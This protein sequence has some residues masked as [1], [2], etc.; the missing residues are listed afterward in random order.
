MLIKSQLEVCLPYQVQ[1]TLPPHPI[2]QTLLFDFRESGSKTTEQPTW[3]AEFYG[4]LAKE[5]KLIAVEVKVQQW[6]HALWCE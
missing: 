4:C 2:Y 5:T 6:M 3:T 1:C